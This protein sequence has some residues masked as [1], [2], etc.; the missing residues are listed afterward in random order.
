MYIP[1]NLK[2]LGISLKQSPGETDAAAVSILDAE[3]WGGPEISQR[4][5]KDTREVETTC[6]GIQ[7]S[8]H[9][10]IH[11]KGLFFSCLF[12]DCMHGIWRFPG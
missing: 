7:D 1:L 11:L 12:Y 4:E 3:L 8:S 9:S 6:G 5:T 2:V 10:P